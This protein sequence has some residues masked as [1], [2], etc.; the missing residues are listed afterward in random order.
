MHIFPHWGIRLSND[1][2]IFFQFFFASIINIGLREKNI[3]QTPNAFPPHLG[4]RPFGNYLMFI[5][6]YFII[7]VVRIL[8]FFSYGTIKEKH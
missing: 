2:I 5:L 3:G 6:F 1:H 4:R 8:V 7:V